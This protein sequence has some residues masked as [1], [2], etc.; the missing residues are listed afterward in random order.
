MLEGPSFARA[1]CRSR[2]RV[3][4]LDP[5]TDVVMCVHSPVQRHTQLS[6]L[7][8]CSSNIPNDKQNTDRPSVSPAESTFMVREV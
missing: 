4:K 1:Q 7:N 8:I 2:P 6:G 5:E 3:M